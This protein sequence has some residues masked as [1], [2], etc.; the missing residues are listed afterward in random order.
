MSEPLK[1]A[2]KMYLLDPDSWERLSSRPNG[3]SPALTLKRDY[4][5]FVE[6]KVA[7]ENKTKKDWNM[8]A[9]QVQPIITA[10]IK[11][12]G[13]NLAQLFANKIKKTDDISIDAVVEF[14]EALTSLSGVKLDINND[15]LYIDGEALGDKGSNMILTLLRPNA[16]LTASKRAF[17]VK[18]MTRA[19]PALLNYVKNREALFLAQQSQQIGA[20]NRNAASLSSRQRPPMSKSTPGEAATSRSTYST[21]SANT[22]SS[23]SLFASPANYSPMRG[24]DNQVF[25]NPA[26]HNTTPDRGRRLV[27]VIPSK[28][29]SPGFSYVRSATDKPPKTKAKG[30]RSKSLDMFSPVKT[31]SKA[32]LFPGNDQAGKGLNKKRKLSGWKSLF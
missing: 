9:Q 14:A 22:P 28:A 27:E 23:G 6:N 16:Q 11:N 32:Q 17:L 4:Q 15:K 31:R 3:L 8:I 7:N 13:S 29:L 18:V 26:Q 10:G 1:Y 25:F 20:F 2:R 19:N 30:R 5:R 21:P 24:K 12:A